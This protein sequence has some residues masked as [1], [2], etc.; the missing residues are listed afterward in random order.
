[1]AFKPFDGTHYH[2]TWYNIDLYSYSTYTQNKKISCFFSNVFVAYIF[3]T[4][5]SRS[6]T[7]SVGLMIKTDDFPEVAA[8]RSPRYERKMKASTV[9]DLFRQPILLK[10]PNISSV[11]AA[12]FACKKVHRQCNCQY[13]LLIPDALLFFLDCRRAPAVSSFLRRS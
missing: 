6:L 3:Q 12:S 1:M 10:I 13:L 9:S 11:C 5:L 2:L 4:T 7:M 8:N